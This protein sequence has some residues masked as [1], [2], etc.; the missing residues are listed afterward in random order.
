[1]FRTM[2]SRILLAGVLLVAAVMGVCLADG[3]IKININPHKIVLNAQG[4][5]DSIQA[6]IPI[7]LTS[8][9]IPDFDVSLSFDG[10]ADLV[11]KAES[12]R[13]CVI[14]NMLIIGFDRA[15]L[16]ADL[17]DALAGLNVTNM[18]TTA[19]VVGS[20]TDDNGVTKEFE[21]WDKVKIVKPGKKPGKK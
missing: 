17:V 3:I 6:N 2:R 16:Q 19:K 1:M 21:G 5:A 10:I 7:V 8:A 20:V 12:A 9:Y 15:S 4:K 14:D 11:A 13:Y 18:T